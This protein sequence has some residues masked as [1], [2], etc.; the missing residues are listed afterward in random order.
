M[1]Y[2]VIEST[3][4]D[5]TDYCDAMMAAGWKPQGGVSVVYLKR[6]H[7]KEMIDFEKVGLCKTYAFYCQAFIHHLDDAKIPD[8]VGYNFVG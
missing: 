8:S 6:K 1:Q 2:V 3:G 5:F 7:A 4:A